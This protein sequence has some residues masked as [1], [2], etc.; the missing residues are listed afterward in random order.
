M[1]TVT[2]GVAPAFEW[3]SRTYVMGT[4]NVTPAASPTLHVTAFTTPSGG[5]PWN[6]I[7]GGDGSV[8]YT[9][10]AAS[11]PDG[12]A[13]VTI[14]PVGQIRRF[15]LG[16]GAT[17][18]GI[19]ASTDGVEDCDAIDPSLMMDGDGKLWLSY[20]TFFGFIRVL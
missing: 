1:E 18:G 20:G 16:L 13:I 2:A 5:S 12:G 10:R 9:Q 19:V 6:I 4:V 11:A 7:G 3:G 17:P 14:A 15:P 8:W